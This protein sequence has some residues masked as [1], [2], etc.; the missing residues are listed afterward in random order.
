V[1]L[2]RF[3]VMDKKHDLTHFFFLSSGFFCKGG[4]NVPMFFS[5]IRQQ[6]VLAAYLGLSLPLECRLST[7]PDL[8][9]QALK[10][11]N[12]VCSDSWNGFILK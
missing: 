7:K 9:I 1:E 6:R 11:T 4:N 12:S 10:V 3:K 8:T 2:V 5:G